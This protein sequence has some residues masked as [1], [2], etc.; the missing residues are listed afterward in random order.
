MLALLVYGLA[1]GFC[2]AWAMSR[3][4]KYQFMGIS[5]GDLSL[6]VFAILSLSLTAF[7]AG[8]GP[9]LRTARMD[10]VEALRR[11]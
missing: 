8:L 2:L 11:E 10:P 7:L 6:L 9:A 5:P 1:L 4:L 3:L